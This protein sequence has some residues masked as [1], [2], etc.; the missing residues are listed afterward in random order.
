VKSLLIRRQEIMDCYFNTGT[1]LHVSL[2]TCKVTENYSSLHSF[3]NS[4]IYGEC[5]RN[6]ARHTITLP[7]ETFSSLFGLVIK[8]SINICIVSKSTKEEGDKFFVWGCASE[9]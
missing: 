8:V 2:H 5:I 3:K 6:C 4:S 7:N 9:I 1:L